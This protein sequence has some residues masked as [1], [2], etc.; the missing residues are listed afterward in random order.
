MG[1]L[2]E[3]TKIQV[4]VPAFE[5]D[6]CGKHGLVKD[7]IITTVTTRGVPTPPVL[8]TPGKPQQPRMPMQPE[9]YYH[10]SQPCKDAWWNNAPV[11]KSK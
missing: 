10:C 9:T 4:S 1:I 2:K 8:P 6:Q 11:K 3:P 5:C 7:A